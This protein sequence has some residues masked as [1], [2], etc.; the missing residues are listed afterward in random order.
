MIAVDWDA[1]WSVIGRALA[2][3]GVGAGAAVLVFKFLGQRLVEQAL[4]KNLETHRAE[5]EQRTERL[6]AELSIYAHEHSVARSRVDV[7][8]AEAIARIHG[9]MINWAEATAGLVAG[10]RTPLEYDPDPDA[11]PHEDDAARWRHTREHAAR[12]HQAGLALTQC[13]QQNAIY[14]DSRTEE[15]VRRIVA[16]STGRVAK[17]VA[18]IRDYDEVM[19]QEDVGDTVEA[20]RVE[21]ARYYR[22]RIRLLHRE[23]ARDFRRILGFDATDASAPARRSPRA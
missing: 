17:L 16:V 9:A 3:G 14:L 8:R 19:I 21:F 22:R 23:A 5:L 2:A 7:H 1:T 15:R 12:S 6:K 20:E 4:A 13:V 11:H 10:Y 18:G